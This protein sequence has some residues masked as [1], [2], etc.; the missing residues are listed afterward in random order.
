MKIR[1]PAQWTNSHILGETEP[2]PAKT[3]YQFDYHLPHCVGFVTKC[4]WVIMYGEQWKQLK[5]EGLL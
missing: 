5:E 2:K 1:F 3:K 4:G